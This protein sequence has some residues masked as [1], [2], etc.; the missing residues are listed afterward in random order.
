MSTAGLEVFDRTLHETNVWLRDVMAEMGPDRQ[1][2]YHALRAVL[3]AL[4]D[5]LPV[6]VSAHL[7][8]QLPLLVRGIYYEGWRPTDTPGRERTPQEFLAQ[9]QKHL[10]GAAP[11]NADHA[12]KAVLRTLAQHV[13]GGEV[14]KVKRALPEPLRGL[15]PTG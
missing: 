14:E 10:A 2:A 15:F 4:R 7:T 6:E 9:V 8:A 11:V 13:S 12:T 3:H 5:R 1:R